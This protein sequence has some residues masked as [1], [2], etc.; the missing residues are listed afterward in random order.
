MLRRTLQNRT[1]KIDERADHDSLPTT[2]TIHCEPSPST[3]SVT[4]QAF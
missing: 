1:N 4:L 2:E 3:A